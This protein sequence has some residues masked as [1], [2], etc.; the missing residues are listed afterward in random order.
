[1]PESLQNLS[2]APQFA[3]VPEAAAPDNCLPP[4]SAWQRHVPAQHHRQR[5]L[6]RRQSRN[7]RE[8]F[9]NSI[10]PRIEYNA[11][12]PSFS[13]NS[14]RRISSSHAS[15]RK[16]GCWKGLGRAFQ[17]PEH[18]YHGRR[19]LYEGGVDSIQRTEVAIAEEGERHNGVRP[20]WRCTLT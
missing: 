8:L 6:S 17:S 19:L 4:V 15:R 18:A 20:A 1:M 11:D 7:R 14:T 9:G 16:R 5:P 2:H 10:L 3:P 12:A 13:R